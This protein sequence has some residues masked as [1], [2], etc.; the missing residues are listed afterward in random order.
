[1]YLCKNP[2]AASPSFSI[3]DLN[4]HEN[5]RRVWGLGGLLAKF[6]VELGRT[7]ASRVDMKR[8][9]NNDDG[10]SQMWSPANRIGRG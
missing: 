10:A 8:R 2:A 1:L 5:Q 3:D 4:L 7:R 9:E 6:F